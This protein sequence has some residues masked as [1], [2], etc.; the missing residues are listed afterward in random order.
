MSTQ[1]TSRTLSS[2]SGQKPHDF[3]A[4]VNEEGGAVN[5][6]YKRKDGDYGILKPEAYT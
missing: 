6:V 1:S 2:L 5:V 4:F 3:F